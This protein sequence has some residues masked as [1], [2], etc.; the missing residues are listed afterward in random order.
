MAKYTS[1]VRE[2]TVEQLN[3][4]QAPNLP[5]SPNVWNVWS[6]TNPHTC[7]ALHLP[8]TP[9]VWDG[10]KEKRPIETFTVSQGAYSIY[11]YVCIICIFSILY[12][13]V[14]LCIKFAQGTT[15]TSYI[16]IHIGNRLINILS[17]TLFCPF[18]LF[19]PNR[20]A[21]TRNSGKYF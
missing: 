18:R 5:N 12:K 14:Q 21:A 9:V 20:F 13:Y 16:I 10:L 19:T 17:Y 3:T 8:S 2:M 1:R 15:Y 7:R 4:C 6:M 11:M